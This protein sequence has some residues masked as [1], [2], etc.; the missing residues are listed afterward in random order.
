LG[1]RFSFF[2]FFGRPIGDVVAVLD[3]VCGFFVD[4]LGAASSVAT[5]ATAYY[6]TSIVW[7]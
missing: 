6:E 2:G 1:F 7:V 5:G 3:S 4:V